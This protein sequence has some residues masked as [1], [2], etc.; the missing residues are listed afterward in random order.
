[1]NNDKLYLL[2]N[3]SLAK[4]LKPKSDICSPLRGLAFSMSS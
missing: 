3:I 2:G 1:M 4:S